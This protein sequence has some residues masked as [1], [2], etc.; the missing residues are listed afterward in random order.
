[1]IDEF[2][3]KIVPFNDGYTSL[4][5]QTGILIGF[6]HHPLCYPIRV[7]RVGLCTAGAKG[8]AV[9]RRKEAEDRE[10]RGFISSLLSSFPYCMSV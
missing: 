5:M 4:D 3:T 1:M 2:N 7:R 8:P 10:S 9:G 6:A